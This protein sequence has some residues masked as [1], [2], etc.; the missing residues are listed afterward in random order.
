MIQRIQNLNILSKDCDE[1]GIT[2]RNKNTRLPDRWRHGE[3][4]V[5]KLSMVCLH[6]NAFVAR[7][8]L[9]TRLHCGTPQVHL[10]AIYIVSS[11]GTSLMFPRDLLT[12]Y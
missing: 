4:Q 6:N 8:I 10:S 11:V 12:N 5:R 9:V 1:Q 2:M 7:G 3:G